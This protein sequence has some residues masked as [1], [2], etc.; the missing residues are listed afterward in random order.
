MKRDLLICC[1]LIIAVSSS[2][3]GWA[4]VCP[5]G[6]LKSV[7]PVERLGGDRDREDEGQ[8]APIY[9]FKIQD[10]D[11]C[12]YKG[13][14]EAINRFLARIATGVEQIRQRSRFQQVSAKVVLHAGACDTRLGSFD[15]TAPKDPNWIISIVPTADY[16][17]K[18]SRVSE[19]QDILVDVWLSSIQLDKLEIPSAFR[20]ESGREIETFLERH[21]M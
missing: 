6:T 21:Q 9:Y 1:V 18:G 10:S 16:D 15:S 12:F 20:V 7:N 8:D 17:S 13:D 5:K 3:W 11:F 2:A 14:T 19:S 4:W